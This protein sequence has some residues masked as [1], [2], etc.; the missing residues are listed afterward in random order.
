MKD[1][2]KKAK[3]I[4]GTNRG[5]TNVVAVNGCCYGIDDKFEK[6]DYLKLC[7]QRFWEFISGNSELYFDIIEPLSNKAKERNELFNSEYA[8]IVTKFSYDFTAEFCLPDAAID[9]Q[10]LVEFNSGKTDKSSN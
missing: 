3:R 7:G 1:N 2:F 6:G 4:L 10:K 8:K 9:W 5:K